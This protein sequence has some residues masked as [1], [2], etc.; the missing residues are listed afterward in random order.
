V[1]DKELYRLINI[2]YSYSLGE[3]DFSIII[4]KI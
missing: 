4:A 3:V 2:N 1:K